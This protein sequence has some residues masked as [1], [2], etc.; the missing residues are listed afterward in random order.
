MWEAF[1][2]AALYGLDNLTVIVDVNRLGQP[3]PTE[4]RLGPGR[5]TGAAWRRSAGARWSSTATTC[6]AIDDAFAT[7]ERSDRPTVI[8]AKTIKGKGVPEVE[9]KNGWHGK[10]V[11]PRVP[12]RPRSRRSAACATCAPACRRRRPLSGRARRSRG[13]DGRRCPSYE[14]G[15]KVATRAA[16]GDALVALGARPEVVVIDGE[17]G[18]STYTEKFKEAYPDRFFEMYIAEQQ[19]VGAAVGL[20]ARG[21]VPFAS[22]FAAF[23]SRAYDF[24][25]MA[26]VSQANI[27]LC[28]SHAGVEIGEDGPSQMGLEDLAMMRAVHGLH[29]ALPERRDLGGGADHGD[30]RPRGHRLHAHHARRLPGAL[31]ARRGVP[32]RRVEGR[33][34]LGATTR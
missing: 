14:L 21:Y 26:A 20:S 16:Y 18:N 31:R 19:M 5:H 9:D 33:A 3:G 17:V 12:T 27:R 2:K 32:G 11:P 24:I 6:D 22:T 10:P 30:G 7:A 28:G 29:R 34:R 1:D 15:T 4:H 25:R 8:L 13:A 23:L